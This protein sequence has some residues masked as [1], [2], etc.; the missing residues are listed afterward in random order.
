[1]KRVTLN[2]IASVTARL[3]LRKHAVLGEHIPA[4]AG[5]VVA[6][7]VL[8]SKNTY[9][10]LE[11]VHGR[12]VDL[13]PG[14]LIA[15]ALGQRHALHGYSGVVPERVEVGDHLHLL[16]MGGV[17]GSGAEAVPGLGPPHTLEVLGSVLTFA[18]LDRSGGKAAHIADQAIEPLPLSGALPP[19]LV[20]LGTSMDAGKTTAAAA[21]IT[22]LVQRGLRVAAGKLTGVSLRRDILQMADSGAAPVCLFTDFGVVTSSEDNAPATARAILGH[23]AESEPDL[24]V[25]EMGDGL[26]GSYG[27]QSILHDV[28]LRRA[29]SCLV[30][31]AQDPVGAWGAQQLLAEHYGL[32]A[33][34][35]SGPVSDTPVGRG[36]CRERLGLPA[37]NALLDPAALVDACAVGLGLETKLEVSR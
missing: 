16:N 36:F 34:V 7:R 24:V 35:V 11:D 18:G 10:K 17:I 9:N 23:L 19:V 1:M 31:C 37:C 27:V 33:S 25:L 12:Q 28:E 13:R 2:K 15:G 20:L 4:R 32:Q 29:V 6:C 5:T 21:V 14:D 30:L 26:L 8:T 3:G 22:G